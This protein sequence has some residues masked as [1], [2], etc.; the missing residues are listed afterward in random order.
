MSPR[1][2]SPLT[3]E[4]ILLGLLYKNP[5]HG[6]ELHKVIKHSQEI[7]KIWY[8]K[9]GKLYSILERLEN[10]G[11]LTSESIP[12]E[13]TPGRKE[14]RVTKDGKRTFLNWILLPVRKPRNM[15]LVFHA[16]LYFAIEQGEETAFKLIEAQRKECRMWSERM[17][18][19]L[20]EAKESG[21][22]SEHIVNYRI[23]QIE[24]M[25]VWLDRCEKDIIVR[26]KVQNK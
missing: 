8:V 15:R 7:S 17:H 20:I 16:R 14:F 25:L 9:L 18:S 24:A 21:F 3:I 19:Q 1:Q 22:I 26:M 6:Y 13:K 4:Y 2:R 23:G 11:L 5:K 10:D 12:S